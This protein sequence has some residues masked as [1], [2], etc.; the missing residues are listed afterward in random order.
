MRKIALGALLLLSITSCRRTVADYEERA[1]G[2]RK[3]CPHCTFVT[4]E[5]RYYAVDTSKQP[6][7]I[8]IVSFK[9]GGFFYTASDV[10]HLI[11]VN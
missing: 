10:D 8:Y 11:R 5:N 2:V 9:S 7:I 4:S 1:A 6:N 3:V